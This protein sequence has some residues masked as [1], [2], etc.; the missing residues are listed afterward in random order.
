MS[1]QKK[2]RSEVHPATDPL[3]GTP[4]AAPAGRETAKRANFMSGELGRFGS[5]VG[6]IR[7]IDIYGDEL[8]RLL[9]DGPSDPPGTV[10]C[11]FSVANPTL[12]MRIDGRWDVVAFGPYRR[13]ATGVSRAQALVVVATSRRP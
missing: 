8:N 2:F 6:R 11:G 13:I 10:R 7:E 1:A 5:G 9:D 4:L 12:V 3:R